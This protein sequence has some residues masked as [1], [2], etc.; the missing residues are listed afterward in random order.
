MCL[1]RWDSS[2][3][4]KWAKT[5]VEGNLRSLKIDFVKISLERLIY[6]NDEF[7]V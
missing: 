3:L 6:I 7:T 1:G 4:A 2:D 5:P